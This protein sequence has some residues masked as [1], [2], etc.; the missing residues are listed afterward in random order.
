MNGPIG[1]TSLL[2]RF[3]FPPGNKKGFLDP[4]PQAAL[5]LVGGFLWRLGTVPRGTGPWM[6]EDGRGLPTTKPSFPPLLPKV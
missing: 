3:P 6:K 5:S 2:L 1:W 4:K